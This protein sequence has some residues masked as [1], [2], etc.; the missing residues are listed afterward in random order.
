MLIG[1]GMI[2]IIGSDWGD[3]RYYLFGWPGELNLLGEGVGLLALIF[4]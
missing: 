2:I 3:K 1:G 4:N